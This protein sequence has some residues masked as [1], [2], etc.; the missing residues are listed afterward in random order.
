MSFSKHVLGAAPV[1]AS[2]AAQS[3]VCPPDTRVSVMSVPEPEVFHPDV[4]V[5]KFGLRTKFG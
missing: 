1:L 2:W 5:S 4:F 3:P